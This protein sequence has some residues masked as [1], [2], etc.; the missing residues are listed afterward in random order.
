MQ[1]GLNSESKGS[2]AEVSIGV[3]SEEHR[4]EKNHDRVPDRRRPAKQREQL[5]ADE[6]LDRKEKGCAEKDCSREHRG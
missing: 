5:F 3:S 4:L 1:P 2:D 6:R